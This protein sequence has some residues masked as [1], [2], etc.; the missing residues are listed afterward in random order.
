M[1]VTMND[2]VTFDVSEQLIQ[3]AQTIRQQ[4]D[5]RYG[6]IFSESSSDMRW[7]GEIGELITRDAMN[8]CN[9]DATVWLDQDVTSNCDINFCGLGVEVKTVKRKVPMALHYKAQITARHANKAM[10]QLLFTCYEFPKRKLHILGAMTK[11]E[12]LQKAEYFK[13]GDQVH[14]NY[15]IRPG[16]EIYSVMVS[17]M[18][19]VRE[20]LRSAMR[21]W[22][23][24]RKV[25]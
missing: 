14:A 2:I 1:A 9:Q 16:H 23:T 22:R 19:P 25:A 7:V 18:N 17:E 5:Q 3:Q 8:L 13:E 15:T 21:E 11:E 12:F 10:D 6:N 4:R 24:A 20:F